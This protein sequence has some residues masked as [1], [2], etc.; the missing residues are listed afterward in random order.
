M[1]SKE[2]IAQVTPVDARAAGLLDPSLPRSGMDDAATADLPREWAGGP[3]GSPTSPGENPRRESCCLYIQVL[4]DSDVV[5]EQDCK[6]PDYCWNAGICKDICKARTRVLPGTFSVDLLSDTEFLVYKLPKTGRGMSETESAL[7]ADF[8]GGS[9]LWAGVPADVFVTPR[10]IQQARRDKAKTREYHRR[11]TVE[12]LA[13]AQARLRDLDLTA[14]KQK[15]LRENLVGR[16]RG[17]IQRVDKY[18]AQQHGKEPPWASGPVSAPPVLPDRTATPDDYLSAREPLEFEYDSEETDPGEPEDDP[19]EDDAS[20]SSDSTYKSN[21]H[22]TDRTR[23]TNISNCNHRH[24]Q[25]KRKEHRFRHP[26][27]AKKEEDRRK[28]K[29]VLSLFR[30]S[31]KEGALTYTDWRWEVEEYLQKGY[32]DNRV[33]DAMLSSVEGQAYV[34]FR[35]CDEG[36]N[37]TP[38]QILREMDSIYNVSVTFQ[39]LNAQICSLKQGMN[40]PIKSYYEWMADISVKLEQY[41]GDHFGPSELSLMKKDCFYARLKEHNKYLVS[42]MK[43]HDQYGPAQMLKEIREQEDSRYLANTTPKPHNQ[44]N[45]NK[46]ANHYGGKGPTYDKT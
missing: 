36:R 28:G 32:D 39:D 24:N 17:M 19:E 15:E 20:I 26:T 18:L 34:N 42:H 30:D 29:V 33:K 21:R 11:I 3:V 8:I 38:A 4:R 2:G 35:S 43:D 41:H 40:E 37:R 6:V 12:R 31:P 45:H 23:R 1:D 46:N 22:D 9:Y 44:D 10:T 5:L 7:F 27:N 13:A 16:G 14:R 25:R